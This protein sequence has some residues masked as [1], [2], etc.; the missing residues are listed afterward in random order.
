[1]ESFTPPALPL[2]TRQ[3]QGHGHTAVQREQSF[4]PTQAKCPLMNP[5][6]TT[7]EV[8]QTSAQIQPMSHRPQRQW[9]PNYRPFA[10][11]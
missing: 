7:R 6:Q 11:T 3:N 9:C 4:E 1:M 10:R 8:T 5:T 2:P